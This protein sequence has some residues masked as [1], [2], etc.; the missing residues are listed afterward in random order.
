M[1]NAAHRCEE[2]LS[3]CFP[4]PRN[5]PSCSITDPRWICCSC[6]HGHLC[7][8]GLFFFFFFFETCWDQWPRTVLKPLLFMQKRKKPSS[9]HPTT[10]PHQPATSGW[11]GAGQSAAKIGKLQHRRRNTGAF[12]QTRWVFFVLVQYVLDM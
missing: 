9:K 8:W 7:F 1:K 11:K 6:S 12:L 4:P 2:I 5:P 10:N 3:L